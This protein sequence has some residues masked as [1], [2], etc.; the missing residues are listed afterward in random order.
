[1]TEFIVPLLVEQY[2]EQLSEGFPNLVRTVRA[3]YSVDR[4]TELLRE[5]FKTHRSI[6]DFRGALEEFMRATVSQ[7]AT[8][9]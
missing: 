6:R 9:A 2:L 5:R 8:P 7:P 1:M 4:L 3:V